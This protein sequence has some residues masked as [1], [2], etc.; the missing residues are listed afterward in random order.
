[1]FRYDAELFYAN[2]TGVGGGTDEA[3]DVVD[4]P[5]ECTVIRRDAATTSVSP[6]PSGKPHDPAATE[7]QLD[8]LEY[9]PLRPGS[10]VPEGSASTTT[11]GCQRASVE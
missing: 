9:D 7:A 8:D 6:S 3:P 1:M 4:E 10:S 11:P 2:A 5:I